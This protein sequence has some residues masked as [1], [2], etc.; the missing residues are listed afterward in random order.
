[1]GDFDRQAAIISSSSTGHFGAAFIL[2]HQKSGSLGGNTA[3]ANG[4]VSGLLSFQANDGSHFLEH[5]RIQ[6]S[7]NNASGADDMP[8]ALQFFTAA[9]GAQTVTERMKINNAGAISTVNGGY[10]TGTNN[11]DAPYSNAPI[12]LQNT[13]NNTNV[14]VIQFKAYDGTFSGS[15]STRKAVTTYS[16]SS[17]YRLKENVVAID[18][19]I[20]RVK[21]LNPSRFNFTFESETTVDG[22]LAHEA[23][24]VVPEAVIGTKDEVD[25]EGNPVYQGIDQSKLVPLLTA[26]LQEAIAKIETLEQRLTD[27]GIA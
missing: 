14:T 16:T 6:A 4:D 18:D 7:V 20:A 27:A 24:A 13:S 9:D 25:D 19:G 21:Q 11:G 1:M 26:A 12:V 15:I 22:F 23:Q 3:L 10:F 17:D 5:A 8:G 2:A